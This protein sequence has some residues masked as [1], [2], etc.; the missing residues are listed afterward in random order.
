MCCGKKGQRKDPES[1]VHDSSPV[2]L[3]KVSGG[4]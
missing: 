1:W 2:L 3:I 4:E